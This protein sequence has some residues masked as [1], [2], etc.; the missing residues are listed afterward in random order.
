MDRFLRTVAPCLALCAGLS[1]SA[2]SYFAGLAPGGAIGAFGVDDVAA[3]REAWDGSALR[4][5]WEDPEIREYVDAMLQEGRRA[6]MRDDPDADEDEGLLEGLRRELE[7]AGVDPDELRW[8]GAMGGALFIG[9]DDWDLTN[10]APAAGETSLQL[11]FSARFEDMESADIAWD[12][13][14]RI[15]EKAARDGRAETARAAY[16]GVDI[17]KMIEVEGGEFDEMEGEPPFEGLL[18][19]QVGE[20]IAASTQLDALRTVIDRLEGVGAGAPLAEQEDFRATMAQH[21]D[22]GLVWAALLTA[23]LREMFTGQAREQ[24]LGALEEMAPGAADMLDAV[25]GMVSALGLSEVRAMSLRAGM[26]GP[27][28]LMDA[29]YALLVP[30]KKGLVA[31]FDGQ[32][33]PLSPPSWV[34]ADAAGVTSLNFDFSGVMPLVRSVIGALP[35]EERVQTEMMAGMILTPLEPILA[36]LGDR[37]TIVNYVDRPFGADSSSEVMAMSVADADRLA[38]S[39]GGAAASVGL[40]PRDFQ[41]H[42]LYES[43]FIPFAISSGFGQLFVGPTGAVERALRAGGDAGQNALSADQAFQRDMRA[44]ADQGQGFSYQRTRPEM[45]Y[46]AWL[47]Q[48]MDKVW[49][50]QWDEFGVD[51]PEAKREYLEAMRESTPD[52]ARRPMPVDAMLRHMGNTVWDLRSTPQGFVSHG[53]TLRAGQ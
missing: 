37:M 35:E 22:P 32:R 9:P 20:S 27:A 47:A 30:E 7:E 6:A 8:P 12:A 21:D 48:N 36:S 49:E 18:F 50:A 25:T 24:T 19:A 39:L 38:Q 40:L 43:D 14:E 2:Q 33:R 10:E 26:G 42:Q 29:T 13:L 31:L 23:P 46:G 44:V 11:L 15:S 53:V 41:G 28:S 5:M 16:G 51:D 3:A 1:A 17:L 34:G 52:F 4:A 45:E